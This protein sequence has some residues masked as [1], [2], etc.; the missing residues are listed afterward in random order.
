VVA[1]VLEVGEPVVAWPPALAVVG[2]EADAVVVV[3]L[4]PVVV[5]VFAA[6]VVAGRP[7]AAVDAGFA[8]A[9]GLAT[10]AGFGAGAVFLAC[11]DAMEPR[12]RTEKTVA[13]AS[14]LPR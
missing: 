7:A 2:W 8:V 11:A 6:V 10:A 1:A 3:V 4:P 12:L 13:N 14:S 9:A 5:V